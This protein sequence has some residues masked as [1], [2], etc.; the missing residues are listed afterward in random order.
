MN[1]TINRFIFHL[2]SFCS[3]MP[4]DDLNSVYRVLEYPRLQV[5]VLSLR[6]ISRSTD[7][8]P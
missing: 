3:C 2:L 7:N 1:L 8:F 5:N 4:E 6:E